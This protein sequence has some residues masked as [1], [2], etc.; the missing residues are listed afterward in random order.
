MTGNRSAIEPEPQVSPY[1]LPGDWYVIHSYSGYENKVKANLE[2][3]I[4]S[5]HMEERIFEVHIPMEDVVEFKGGKKVTALKRSFPG[6]S[7][8]GCRWTMTPGTRCVTRRASPVFVAG[9][10]QKP[11]PLSRRE[12]GAFSWCAEGRGKGQ[13]PFQTRVGGWRNRSGSSLSIRRLQRCYRRDQHRSAEGRG[14]GQHLRPR[15]TVEL[16]FVDIQKN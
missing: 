11:T 4:Q 8:S 16:G 13:A 12:V 14:S 6:T 10:A 7:L 2:T 1:D 15:H 3:R 9:N 5:M